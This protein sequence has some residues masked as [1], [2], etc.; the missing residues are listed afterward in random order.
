MDPW[1]AVLEEP[2]RT[3][4]L[5]TDGN[6][7]G[8]LERKRFEPGVEPGVEAGGTEEKAEW[9]SSVL[10]VVVEVALD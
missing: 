5:E 8:E 9:K 3:L 1:S 6:S 4:R 2:P 7:S 10:V